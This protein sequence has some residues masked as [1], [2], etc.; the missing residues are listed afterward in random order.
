MLAIG[1]FALLSTQATYAQRARVIELTW[2]APPGCPSA[3]EADAQLRRLIGDMET[4][5][6]DDPIR[7]AGT[8][9][10]SARGYRLT[11]SIRQH[12]QRAAVTRIVESSSCTG[13]A[14]AGAVILA[15]LARGELEQATATKPVPA[16]A[17]GSTAPRADVAPARA[18]PPA[19]A[20]PAAAVEPPARAGG[21]TPERARESA[22]A[23]SAPPTRTLRR[24]PRILLAGPVLAT[25]FG[26]LPSWAAGIGAGLG[27][28]RER[29]QLVASGLYWLPRWIHADAN[30]AFSGR[31]TR[32]TVEL[33]A[34]YT[35]RWG[36]FEL[37]PCAQTRVEHVRSR[38]RGPYV[39]SNT[40]RATWMTAGPGAV[41]SWSVWRYTTLFART[42]LTFSTVRPTFEIAGVGAVHR[43][44]LLTPGLELGGAC[45]F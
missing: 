5:T 12:P 40:G 45:F 38:G 33:A 25:D 35:W 28:R 8:I 29:L 34:C 21:G 22:D 17:T 24:D 16:D 36:A 9:V 2:R 32:G 44:A 26:L 23:A 20:E 37:G 42:A 43:V 7:A 3:T 41:A 1:V 19:P 31:Y 10:P 30:D 6:G 18:S 15:L 4:T 39:V 11:L 14:G 27:W 13:L